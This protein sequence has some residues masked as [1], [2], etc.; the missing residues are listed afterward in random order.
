MANKG[1]VSDEELQAFFDVG[2]DEQQAL[3]VV[4]GIALATLCNY[5]NNLARC[6]INPEL[7]TYA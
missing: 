2:Y 1:N 6:S 5:S 7:Q 4:L 3:E